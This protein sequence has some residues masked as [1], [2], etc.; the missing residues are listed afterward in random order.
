MIGFLFTQ[1]KS[2]VYSYASIFLLIENILNE[3]QQR[4]CHFRAGTSLKKIFKII[5]LSYVGW[6]YFTI[7]QD[8]QFIEFVLI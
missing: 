4:S 7:V 3:D 1:L 5:T 6:K 8:I 2:T